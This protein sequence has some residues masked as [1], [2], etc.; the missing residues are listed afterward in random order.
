M[1]TVRG[2]KRTT[3]LLVLIL[4]SN[5]LN[6]H[7]YRYKWSDLLF[8]SENTDRYPSHWYENFIM[9]SQ[10]EPENQEMMASPNGSKTI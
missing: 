2:I 1:I 3:A 10:R 5:Y 4:Q 9:R 8:R 6:P 7:R